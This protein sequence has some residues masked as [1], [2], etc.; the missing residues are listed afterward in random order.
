ML[1][2][3]ASA[4]SSK[5]NGIGLF[6]DE[7]V[8]KGT[9]TWKFDPRFDVVFDPKEVENFTPSQQELIKRHGYLS[10]T[11]HQYIFPLDDSR[12]TNHSTNDF[13]IDS[14]YFPGEPEFCGVASRDIEPG[15]EL[16][17]NYRAFD[18]DDAI[19]DKEYLKK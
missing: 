8:S 16:L 6:A 1:T 10:T 18:A 7:R 14:V 2:I 9:V 3:K 12:F 5:I 13:N 15:E 17:A 19:S 11:S 4:R